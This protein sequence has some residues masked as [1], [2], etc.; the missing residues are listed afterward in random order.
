MFDGPF[1]A[2]PRWARERIA[3][4]RKDSALDVLCALIECMDMRTKCTEVTIPQI[5]ERAGVSKE[6]AKRVLHW[7]EQEGILRVYRTGGKAP[8]RYS[9]QYRSMGSPMTPQGVTHDPIDVDA[10]PLYGVTHDPIN[11]AKKGHLPADTQSTIEIYNTTSTKEDI[12]NTD[13]GQGK[14]MSLIIGSDPN[15]NKEEKT[16]SQRKF[17]S[18]VINDLTNHFVHH[19]TNVMRV[20]PASDVAIL[21][22]TLKLLV[23]SGLSPESIRKMIDQF[24]SDSRFSSYDNPILGFS[25]KKIQNLLMERVT[26]TVTTEDPVLSLMSSDFIRGDLDLPWSI[27]AD[28]NLRSAVTTRCLETLYRYPELVADTVRHWSGDFMNPDFLKA[29]SALESLVKT[30]LG[31][32][33]CD[34]NEVLQTLGFLS[35]PKELITGSVRDSAGTMVSAIYRHRRANR[36]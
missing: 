11:G 4:G 12:K 13:D 6:T 34:T 8:N 10:L 18:P 31:K 27:T 1:I 23:S 24:L 32:E 25:S 26:V 33:T 17:S 36:V 35:L 29:L 28:N 7:M 22:R 30:G 3:K 5:A 14:G 20:Y 21:R 16:A 15:E 19:K 2:V 9:V